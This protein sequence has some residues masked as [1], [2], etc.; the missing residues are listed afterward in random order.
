MAHQLQ[1]ATMGIGSRLDTEPL[2][3]R[4]QGVAQRRTNRQW[5]R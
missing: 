3:D 2:E 5:D 4:G 1:A